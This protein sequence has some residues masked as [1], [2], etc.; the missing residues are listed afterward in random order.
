MVFGARALS[1]LLPHPPAAA[2]SHALQGYIYPATGAFAFP[3]C[4]LD[5]IIS[6]HSSQEDHFSWCVTFVHFEVEVNSDPDDSDK[7][8]EMKGEGVRLGAIG[9]P[10]L[11]RGGI[12]KSSNPA[13]GFMRRNRP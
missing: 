7:F 8:E 2:A 10:V 4:E 1:L 6:A 12:T 3:C 11:F 13:A 5:E 9:L